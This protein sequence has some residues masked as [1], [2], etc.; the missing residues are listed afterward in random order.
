MKPLIQFHMERRAQ[1]KADLWQH[2][3]PAPKGAA[4]CRCP[5]SLNK[6]SPLCTPFISHKSI[7]K[8]MLA[9]KTALEVSNKSCKG[10]ANLRCTVRQTAKY[11]PILKVLVITHQVHTATHKKKHHYQCQRGKYKHLCVVQDVKMCAL[12]AK[13]L[14]QFFPFSNLQDNS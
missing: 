9:Q 5:V 4:R 3:W 1:K 12:V 6:S 11:F 7:L 13:L 14:P 2:S 8:L 10:T